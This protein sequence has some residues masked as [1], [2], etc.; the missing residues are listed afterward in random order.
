MIA[1]PNGKVNVE[2]LVS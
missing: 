1:K 2:K